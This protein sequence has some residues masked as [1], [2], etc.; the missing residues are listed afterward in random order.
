MGSCLK[1]DKEKHGASIGDLFMMLKKAFKKHCQTAGLQKAAVAATQVKK[2]EETKK[3]SKKV[4]DRSHLTKSQRK[5]L[6][7]TERQK[8]ARA[9][10]G[11]LKP[12]TK[13]GKKS[14][15]NSKSNKSVGKKGSVQKIKTPKK[16]VM[17]KGPKKDNK[18][19][20]N[21]TKA[22]KMEVE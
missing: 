2:E 9:R 20:Q 21:E 14:N 22:V 5:R 3:P 19:K 6:R 11:I 13:K 15:Q 7:R 18:G 1:I 10:D 4:V 12:S 17:N 16:K 8:L